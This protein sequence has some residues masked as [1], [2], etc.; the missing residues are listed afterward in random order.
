MGIFQ[1]ITGA[2]GSA[3]KEIN[4]DE[5]MTAAESKQ[6]DDVMHAKADAYVK[7]IKLERDSD[8]QRVEEELKNKNIVLLNVSVLSRNPDKL[9]MAIAKLRS[10]TMG[11]NGD[12]ARI[13]DDKILLTPGAVKI[14]KKRK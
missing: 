9:K 3:S 6:T 7:P 13:D 12:I 11:L 1:K 8:M 5:F 2:M 10:F 14:V 4:V